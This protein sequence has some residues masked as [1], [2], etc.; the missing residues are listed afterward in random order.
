MRHSK[1]KS[2][3]VRMGAEDQSDKNTDGGRID[4]DQGGETDR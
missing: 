3:G 4:P 2:N 1:G